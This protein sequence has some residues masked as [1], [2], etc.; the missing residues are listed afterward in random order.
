MRPQSTPEGPGYWSINKR[1]RLC[2]DGRRQSPVDVATNLLVY[3]HLLEPLE[4]RWSD[5]PNWAPS[6]E[7][8]TTM[9]RVNGSSSSEQP[10]VRTSTRAANGGDKVS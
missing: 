7:D 9:S 4:L 8:T 1:W 10:S 2:A 5:Q 3:D 6:D